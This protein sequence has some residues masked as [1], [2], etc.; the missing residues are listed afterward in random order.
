MF[1]ALDMWRRT[2]SS[3][4]NMRRGRKRANRSR[5]RSRRKSIPNTNDDS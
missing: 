2:N 1:T 5:K 4:R 3:R